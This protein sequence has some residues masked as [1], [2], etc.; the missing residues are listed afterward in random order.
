MCTGLIISALSSS[1]PSP[2]V[3]SCRSPPHPFFPGSGKSVV[4]QSWITCESQA[5]FACLRTMLTKSRPT[6]YLIHLFLCVCV[7]VC[8]CVC[9]CCRVC[10]V[11]WVLCG[12][13]WLCVVGVCVWVCVCVCVC[14]VCVCVCVSVSVRVCVCV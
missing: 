6:E 14:G 11:V 13:R 4:F 8:G 9:V 5:E 1:S 2:L 3:C 7:C 12:V 10:V